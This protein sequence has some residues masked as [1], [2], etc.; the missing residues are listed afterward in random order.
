MRKSFFRH[1]H[2]QNLSSQRVSFFNTFC[3]GGSA[4]FFFVILTFTGV[5]LMFAFLPLPGRAADS[6]TD[7]DSVIPFGSLFRNL[8]YWSGQAML[9]CVLLH[10]T[11]VCI[12]GSYQPPRQLNWLVGLGL[13]CLTLAL[14][15]SGYVLRWDLQGRL[16]AVVGT[17]LIKEIPLLGDTFANALLGGDPTQPRG[18]L[19]WYVWHCIVLPQG[20]AVLSLYHFWRIRKD[21]QIAP[22]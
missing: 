1:L 2:P 4:F 10:M 15:F 3:L 18:F 21:G 22:M 11:R 20:I 13:L 6:I 8:H 16:A 7:L 19:H 17:N 12:T 5:L 14:D 9:L